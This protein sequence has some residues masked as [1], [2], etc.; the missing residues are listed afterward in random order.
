[1]QSNIVVH[2]NLKLEV[3]SFNSAEFHLF[4]EEETNPVQSLCLL[5][6]LLMWQRA[7]MKLGRRLAVETALLDLCDWKA[8]EVPWRWLHHE[9]T[10]L[11][12]QHRSSS[13]HVES[14]Y[15]PFPRCIDRHTSS[16]CGRLCPSIIFSTPVT[17]NYK[18]T[19]GRF[20]QAM[21][22]MF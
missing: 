22:N 18:S 19:L 2:W 14:L 1:M 3:N 5:F 11:A 20:E 13:F 17:Y 10:A 12:S 4:R 21:K 16:C 7:V 8:A 9:Q 15:P 6:C